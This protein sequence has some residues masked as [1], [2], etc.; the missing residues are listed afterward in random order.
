MAPKHKPKRTRTQ[1]FEAT[2]LSISE[3]ALMLSEDAVKHGEKTYKYQRARDL[4][5]TGACGK[6]E[7]RNDRMY[8][9][10]KDVEKYIEFN[11]EIQKQK[12]EARAS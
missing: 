12:E 1:N 3:V 6:V 7:W 10:R 11:R 8:V 2:H 5:L 4:V 9:A